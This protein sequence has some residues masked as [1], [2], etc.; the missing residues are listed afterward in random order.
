MIWSPWNKSQDILFIKILKLDPQDHTEGA[1]DFLLT[2]K[3][4]IYII[5]TFTQYRKRNYEDFNK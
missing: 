4:T 1:P 5:F 2:P 3:E